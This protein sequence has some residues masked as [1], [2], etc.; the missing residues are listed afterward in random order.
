MLNYILIGMVLNH[1]QTGYDIK[2]SIELGI[3]NFYKISYGNLY[4]ALKK[5]SEKGLLTMKEEPQGERIKKYY[6]AT[7]QGKAEF[8]KWLSSPIDFKS[9]SDS[10]MVRIFFYD[11]LPEDVCKERLTECELYAKQTLLALKEIEKTVDDE[12]GYYDK[13][14]LY[15]GLQST[16]NSIKWLNHILY[17]KPL[18]DFINHEN[19]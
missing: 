1:E 9:D 4:P 18:K 6:K 7:N 15:L 13:S 8:I 17:K 19:T 5:L 10:L 14:T 3:G 12:P 11:N 16:L 2:K